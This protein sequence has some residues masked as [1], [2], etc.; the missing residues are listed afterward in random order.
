MNA[1]IITILS[2]LII[3]CT[4]NSNADKSS[5]FKVVLLSTLDG[6]QYTLFDESDIEHVNWESGTFKLKEE[7]ITKPHPLINSND[8]FL[9][10]LNDDTITKGQ[11]K[12]A[13]LSS[14]HAHLPTLLY[15]H[16]DE[17]EQ[18]GYLFVV[19]GRRELNIIYRNMDKENPAYPEKL[20][21]YFESKG[22]I[23]EQVEKATSTKY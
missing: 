13:Y 15:D 6:N 7:F 10:I 1:V 23:K 3:S 12:L 14:F 20:R 8:T 9:V 16:I 2:F 21:Q 4:Y 22:L 17:T 19:Y 11:F 18:S 5:G